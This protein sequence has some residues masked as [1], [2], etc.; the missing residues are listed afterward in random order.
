MLLACADVYALGLILYFMVRLLAGF[1]L[2]PVALFSNFLHFALLPALVLLPIMLAL[3]RWRRAILVALPTLAFL[4]LYGGL[5]LPNKVDTV[6]CNNPG[7]IKLTVMT[8]NLG[9]GGTETPPEDIMKV[10][11]ESG[12]DL[13][14][15]QEV[16]AAQAAMMQS[17]L[18]SMYPYQIANEVGKNVH[19]IALISRYPILEWEP[20]YGNPQAMPNL[21]A[22]LDVQSQRLRVL[23]VHP[24]PPAWSLNWRQMYQARAVGEVHLYAQMLGDQPVVLIGD[25][26]ATDQ[27]EEYTTLM[28]SG[29][30]D[31]Y[32]EVGFGFGPTFPSHEGYGYPFKRAIPL[33]RLDYVFHSRHF[34]TLR[35]WVGPDVE[36]DHLPVLAELAWQVEGSATGN[37]DGDR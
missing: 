22:T 21:D 32:R 31:A 4:W 35:A 13:V 23:V 17:R 5:F 36:S 11:V 29:L 2:W 7:C 34:E 19:G 25:L 37:M 8:F 24:P 33:V 30:V 10:V 16:T 26:N 28:S 27:S 14:G 15:F 1:R 6:D 12:A 3:R 18:S 20:F 9:N